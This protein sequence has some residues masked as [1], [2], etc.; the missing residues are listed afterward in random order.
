[1]NAFPRSLANEP[2]FREAPLSNRSD[3]ANV[4]TSLAV[5]RFWDEHAAITSTLEKLDCWAGDHDRTAYCGEA[6]P[7]TAAQIDAITE[8]MKV[9]TDLVQVV[10]LK[11]QDVSR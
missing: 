4:E 6:R 5:A 8:R 7:A 9:V 11:A 3:T 2:R 10:Y 1:M